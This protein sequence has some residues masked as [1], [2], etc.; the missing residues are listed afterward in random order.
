MREVE[1]RSRRV[2]DIV[3]NRNYRQAVDVIERE[4]KRLE[5]DDKP[6]ARVRF[7]RDDWDIDIDVGGMVDFARS[8]LPKAS[9]EAEDLQ[10][11]GTRRGIKTEKIGSTARGFVDLDEDGNPKGFGG[12][13]DSINDANVSVYLGE[14][15]QSMSVTIGGKTVTFARNVCEDDKDEETEGDEIETS[16]DE[17]DPRPPKL[18]IP[19]PPAGYSRQL[20]ELYLAKRFHYIWGW[21]PTF[22]EAGLNFI[23]KGEGTIT[24]KSDLIGSLEFLN[25]RVAVESIT[26]MGIVPVWET[27]QLFGRWDRKRFRD[28]KVG[29]YFNYIKSVSQLEYIKK[30]PTW[31]PQ[32]VWTSYPMLSPYYLKSAQ[33]INVAVAPIVFNQIEPETGNYISHQL[34]QRYIDWLLYLVPLPYTE[35]LSEPEPP[36]SLPIL[37]DDMD[38][39]CCEE[40]I[41]M[42]REIH[43]ALGVRKLLDK[44]FQVPSNMMIPEGKGNH[45]NKDYLEIMSDLFKTIDNYG[46]DAPVTVTVQDTNKAQKGDQSIELKFSSLGAILKAQTELLIELKG[47]SANRLNIQV[48]LAYMMT[49]MYRTLAKLYYRTSAIL[50]GLGIPIV[51]KVVT[52]PIEFNVFGR[53]HWGAGQGFG[54]DAKKGQEPK[55][56]LNDEDTTESMLPDLLEMHDYEVEVDEFRAKSNDLYEVLIGIAAK[57][58]S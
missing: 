58:R 5:A 23:A 25:E 31:F 28:V 22:T 36:P 51:S 40:L 6:R 48:R 57:L 24:T 12:T 43:K 10:D 20:G 47:D 46:F 49:R 27:R 56:D 19:R 41:K 14:C 38:K 52:L 50:D 39:N 11:G 34:Y 44:S 2:K 26:F 9:I 4:V 18:D 32:R 42:T 53:K 33:Q 37:P 1:E 29:V 17:N 8:M 54:K 55:L 16:E 45:A 7:P 3:R 13:I 35:N 15:E 21:Y 30:S